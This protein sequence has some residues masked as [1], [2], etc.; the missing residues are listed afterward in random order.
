M[1]N[2][3][4]D[5]LGR[6]GKAHELRIAPLRIDG[7]LRKPTTIWVVRMA[8]ELYVRSWH[9]PTGSWFRAAKHRG[10]GRIN[11]GGVEEDVAF[12]VVE[13][14]GMNGA[15]DEAY[16][17]GAVT[18]PGRRTK[19]IFLALVSQLLPIDRRGN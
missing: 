16:C 12:V 17:R 15:M 11:A 10:E 19:A 14:D 4:D 3:T 6:I 5:A 13:D 18:F 9:G 7:G 2:W 8:D 1:S